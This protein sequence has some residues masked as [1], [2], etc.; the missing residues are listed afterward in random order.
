MGQAQVNES[1]GDQLSKLFRSG[2]GKAH[3]LCAAIWSVTPLSWVYVLWTIRDPVSLPTCLPPHPLVRLLRSLLFSYALLEVGFSVYYRWLAVRVQQRVPW[4]AQR[5][6]FLREVLVKS[7]ESGMGD[8]LSGAYDADRPPSFVTTKLA[9]N[10]ERAIEFRQQIRAWFRLAAF[11]DIRKDN[12]RDWI[13][14]SFF[15]QSPQEFEASASQEQ[16]DFVEDTLE[17]LQLRAGKRAPEG[18][19]PRV[20]SIRLTID[21]V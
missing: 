10:D 17:L 6:D 16:R 2:H 14:W 15:S 21:P 4:P 7:L 5:L 8:S 13:L 12:V 18:R 3:V 20:N 9:E 11:E 1:F 19:N